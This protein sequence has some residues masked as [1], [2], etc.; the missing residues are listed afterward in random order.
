MNTTWLYSS[1]NALKEPV[2]DIMDGIAVRGLRVDFGDVI[3]V[4]DID[5]D[6]EK[7][8]IFGLI[9]PNGAGKT[10]LIKVMTGLLDPTYGTVTVGGFNVEEHAA[11]MHRMLGFMPDFPATYDDLTTFEFL[12]VFGIAYNLPVDERRERIDMYL[13]LTDLAQKRDSLV[14]T[15]SRGMK[16]RLI[17]AKTLLHDPDFLLLDEPASGLD[18]VARIEMRNVLKKLG[19]TGKTILISSHILTELADFCTSVGI[20]ELGRIVISGTID[21]IRQSLVPHETVIIELAE[22]EG[23]EAES[24]GA[25]NTES[26]SAA[27]A[28]ILEEC[29]G[30]QSFSVD[31]SIVMVQFQGN[32]KARAELLGALTAGGVLVA[33]F[34]SRKENLEDLFMKVG[35]RG[36]M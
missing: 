28:R 31:G 1:L 25:V 12:D 11:D 27:V 22:G 26:G 23:D 36:V 15:L 14:G 2:S 8:Q 3:A 24:T 7:G 29:P 4:R 5:L 33:Q 34:Y 35:A 16:Q 17:L 19:K 13:A 21:D 30:V 20:M 10:T 6:I 32:I 18:P 9:G